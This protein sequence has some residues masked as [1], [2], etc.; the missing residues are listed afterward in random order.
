MRLLVIALLSLA[1]HH[2]WGQ[3][4]P[5]ERAV[6]RVF[7]FQELGRDGVREWYIC[8]EATAQLVDT[9]MLQNMLLKSFCCSHLVWSFDDKSRISVHRVMGCQEPPI[10]LV[11][12]E[13]SNLRVKVF[14][15]FGFSWVSLFRG[16]VPVVTYKVLELMERPGMGDEAP[17][18]GLKLVA[19]HPLGPTFVQ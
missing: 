11:S 4:P 5:T 8:S 16:R 13:W 3:S 2:G 15:Q 19:L 14:E 12:S 18:I 6:E 10:G 17:F 1:P 7:S 9:I